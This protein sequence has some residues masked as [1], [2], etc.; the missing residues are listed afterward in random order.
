MTNLDYENTRLLDIV[1]EKDE[2]IGSKSRLEVHELGLIHREIHVFM[3]DEN[4]NVFFQ[5]KGIHK[6]SAG[7]LDATVAGHVNKGEKYLETALRETKEETGIS[8]LSK[9]L[10]LLQTL[11]VTNLKPNEFGRPI[12]NFIR[13]IYICTKPIEEAML[14]KE[15]GIQGGGFKKFSCNFLINLKKSDWKIF[16]HSIPAE[17]PK[18]LKYLS[19]WTK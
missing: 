7:L 3:F 5:K 9:D 6:P 15:E 8:I 13:K 18:V 1:N 2:I 17:L 11:K 14:V 19:T 16:H 4:K 12:N 10:F